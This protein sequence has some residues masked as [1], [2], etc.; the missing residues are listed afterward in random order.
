[1]KDKAKKRKKML[2]QSSEEQSVV[3]KV[4]TESSMKC[5]V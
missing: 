3:V 4:R 2:V 1:M 5:N